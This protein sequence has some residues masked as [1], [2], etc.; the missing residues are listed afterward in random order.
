MISIIVPTFNRK[1]LLNK[2]IEIL[3]YELYGFDY[4]LIIVNDS[5]TENVEFNFENKLIK[6]VNNPKQGVASARN[7][8]AKFA[9]FD[10][11]LFMDDDMLISKANFL[12]YLDYTNLFERKTI[13]LE[14]VYSQETN[15]T[16][17]KSAFGRFLMKFGFNSLIGW[18]NLEKTPDKSGFYSEGITSNNLFI[19]KALFTESGGYNET[20]PHAGAED[21]EF[22]ERLKESGFTFYVDCSS[23][24]IHNEIDRLTVKSWMQRKYR[25]GITKRIA[26]DLGYVDQFIPKKWYFSIASLS[27][28][29]V[30]SVLFLTNKY[31]VL[32]K[33]N[34]L[35]LKFILGQSLHNGFYSKPFKI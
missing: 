30:R 6:I 21:F 23:Q 19:S 8:G 28:P 35:C 17:Y 16:L 7:L 11:L 13:N 18:N 12:R 3:T 29:C 34:F 10:F 5:K 22:S 32:D 31:V 4:E 15:E 9:R 20:F 24:M 33:I 25:D 26:S 27:T 14:W 1:E 2:H